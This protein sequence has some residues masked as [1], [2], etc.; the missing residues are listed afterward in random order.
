[1]E[2]RTTARTPCDRHR[3]QRLSVMMGWTCNGSVAVSA[4]SGSTDCRPPPTILWPGSPIATSWI[5]PSHG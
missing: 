4:R 3:S 2:G 1:M 5:E